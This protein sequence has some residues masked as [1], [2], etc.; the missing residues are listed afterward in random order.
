MGIKIVKIKKLTREAFAPYGEIIEIPNENPKMPT[1]EF[2]YWPKLGT[3][4]VN[5]E[6]QVGVST[7]FKRPLRFSKMERH[8]DTQEI[9]IPLNGTI[10]IPFRVCND[11][12]PQS[13]PSTDK[14]DVFAV[15]TLHGVI[16]KRGIWH[17]T[18]MPLEDKT[19]IV[20]IF[21]TGT[22]RNDLYIHEFPSGDIVEA[23]TSG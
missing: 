14:I 22:E 18:P 5:G 10:V 6:L 3:M 2:N 11:F 7:F 23:V 8:M 19:S 9:M 17:W 16:L 4:Q 15:D 20:V 13:T 12:N 21:N 1:E